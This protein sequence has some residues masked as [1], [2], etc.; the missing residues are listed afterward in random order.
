MSDKLSRFVI[1]EGHLTD[2]PDRMESWTEWLTYVGPDQWI[3]S[4]EGTDFSG[5]EEAEPLTESFA[6]EELLKWLQERD[7][8]NEPNRRIGKR[9]RALRAYAEKSKLTRLLG[10]I[11]GIRR[12][13]WPPRPPRPKVIAV[14]DVTLVPLAPH[15][16]AKPIK[17]YLGIETTR[18]LGIM[19]MP[20]PNSRYLQCWLGTNPFWTETWKTRLT[21]SLAEQVREQISE[22][23]KREPEIPISSFTIVVLASSV[24]KY[25]GGT[26]QFNQ[27]YPSPLHN[28]FLHAVVVT[29]RGELDE[30][31]ERLRQSGLV[32]GQDVA[33]GEMTQGELISCPGIRFAFFERA[34][35][36]RW[37]AVYDPTFAASANREA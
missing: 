21:K 15:P 23:L 13:T 8:E 20:V 5:F 25:W 2:A 22:R 4:M 27:D 14:S 33:V 28:C 16:R 1:F 24:S 37:Y 17:P 32:P 26:H 10:L 30:T 6:T 36:P 29:S 18:G 9:L 12:G 3:L 7:S 19:A 11:E 31:L 35:I 34:P